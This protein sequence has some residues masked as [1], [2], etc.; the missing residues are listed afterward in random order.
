MRQ[1]FQHLLSILREGSEL[2]REP[3]TP[4]G[5]NPAAIPTLR[6]FPER[7]WLRSMRRPCLIIFPPARLRNTIYC[8]Y[9]YISVCQTFYVILASEKFLELSMHPP[10]RCNVMLPLRE[11]FYKV[12]LETLRKTDC[13]SGAVLRR[14]SPLKNTSEINLVR[15]YQSKLLYRAF[16]LRFSSDVSR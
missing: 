4:H 1:S 8:L 15:S 12:H 13:F 2:Q 3:E 11:A 5:R 14:N 9:I 10:L 16:L 7:M 6:T